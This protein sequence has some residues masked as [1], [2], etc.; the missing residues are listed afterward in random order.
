MKILVLSNNPLSLSNSNGRTLLNML[1]C[2]NNS[3]ILNIYINGNEPAL[4]KGTFYRINETR[5]LKNKK[6]YGKYI[7]ENSS[8]SNSL[9]TKKR[10][11]PFKCLIRSCLW[12]KKSAYKEILNIAKSFETERII[13]QCGD[14][15]FLIRIACF[16]SK[17]LNIKL[18][19]YNSEDYIFKTWN[20]IEKKKKRS[21]FFRI[22]LRR[23]KKTYSFLYKTAD[24]FV[25]LTDMLLNEYLEIFPNQKGYVIYNSSNIKPIGNYDKTGPIVYSGNLGVGRADTL[26]Q[27]S[28]YIYNI[29][30]KKLTICSLTK[31]MTVLS[32]ISNCQFIDFIGELEYK[33]NIN[34]LEKSSLI[35]HVE[36]M[37]D[38]YVK[39]TKNAFSTKIA[40][41][42]TIG[43]P[44]F[45]LAPSSSSISNYIKDNDCA[46]IANNFTDAENLLRKIYNDEN[47]RMSKLSNGLKTAK[48]NHDSCRNSNLF[49]RIV[50]GDEKK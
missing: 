28:E 18:I 36:S 46:F 13:I 15:D 30:N 10:K 38:Y 49:Y 19:A 44:F 7:K 9:I 17:S 47:F 21:I 25:Y 5:I 11:T 4:E 20:Y 33:D 37:D 43:V 12:S 39:D 31:D 3:E 26:I 22:F 27:L 2:F 34:L 16:L 41:S 50:M 14:S 23:L 29:F 24:S 35:I 1:E 42:L 40:D 32:T 8:N 45:V 6:P 48:M